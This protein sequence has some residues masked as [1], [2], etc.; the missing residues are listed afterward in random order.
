MKKFLIKEKLCAKKRK[1]VTKSKI[2]KKSVY[3][4]LH[5]VE[6]QIISYCI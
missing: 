5:L 4:R 1:I 6:V 2:D 3:G